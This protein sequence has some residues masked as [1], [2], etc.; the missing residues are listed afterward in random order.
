[1]SLLG[2]LLDWGV[3]RLGKVL[4]KVKTK[5]H[6]RPVPARITE[7]DLDAEAK[8]AEWERA[9]RDKKLRS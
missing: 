2:D 5:V 9:Q 7:A 8:V 1:M 4:T 3:D 6:A